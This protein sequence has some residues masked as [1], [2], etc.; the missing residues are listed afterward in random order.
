[1][2]GMVYYS[3]E[4]SLNCRITLEWNE[5][6]T[7]CIKL[8]VLIDTFASVGATDAHVC[9]VELLK[10]VI[11]WLMGLHASVIHTVMLQPID[12]NTADKSKHKFMVQS[13][14]PPPGD[15]KLEEIVRS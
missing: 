13:L 9:V 4:D 1:M 7:M 2:R 12:V 5:V 14:V 11:K 3:W 15:V 8:A 6:Y 10:L